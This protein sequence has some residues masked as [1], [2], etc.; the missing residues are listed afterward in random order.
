LSNDRSHSKSGPTATFSF[1]AHNRLAAWS[2]ICE[3][4][5]ECL[6][7]AVATV[8]QAKGLDGGTATREGLEEKAVEF[9]KTGEIY[10]KV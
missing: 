7:E 8:L 3:P 4:S 1:A 5:R 9:A 2:S 6:K 10:Q